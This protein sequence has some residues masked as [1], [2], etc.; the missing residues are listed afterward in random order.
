MLETKSKR[1]EA[2][3]RIQTNLN[4]PIATRE[5]IEKM[6]RKHYLTMTDII[7]NAVEAY[8]KSSINKDLQ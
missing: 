2:I 5:K 6:A 4:L 1:R 8:S 3:P 7:I